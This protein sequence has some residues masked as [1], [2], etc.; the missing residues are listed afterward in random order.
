MDDDRCSSAKLRR[1]LIFVRPAP[2]IGHCPTAEHT[3]VEA[4]LVV[5]IGD[6]RIVDQHDERLATDVDA[7][8]I[9]PAILGRNDAVADEH[10]L[11][12]RD[13]DF[14]FL[15]ERHRDDVIRE[16]QLKM[17]RSRGKARADVRGI[18]GHRYRFDISP[19]CVAWREAKLS[20]PGDE[21]RNGHVLTVCTRAAAL[22]IVGGK[23]IDVFSNIG[24]ANGR[25][26]GVHSCRMW[27]F[28]GR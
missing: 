4:T 12:V 13:S 1:N 23:D 24:L 2:V 18:A 14:R 7:L 8:V 26:R 11:G 22:K 5:R 16:L 9:V 10:Q 27:F 25:Q 28:V 21:V 15:G 19:V 17:F 20:E 6:R 3:V